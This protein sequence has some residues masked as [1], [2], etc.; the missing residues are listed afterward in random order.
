MVIPS[1]PLAALAC[2]KGEGGIGGTVKFY[3]VECG[4]LIVAEITGLPKQESGF[5]ALHIHAGGS[6][7]GT[8]FSQTQGHFDPGGETHPN[9]VGDLP[10][11]LSG[12]GKAFLAVESSRLCV[13]DIIGRTVVIHRDA[14]DFRSQPAG[15][16]GRKIACGQIRQC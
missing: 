14:D 10:P 3:P 6:C 9:H 4:T 2:V 7:G 13:W 16:A 8:E 11:L 12:N 1:G 5:Y 15:N